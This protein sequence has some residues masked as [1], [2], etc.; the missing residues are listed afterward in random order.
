MKKAC[1]GGGVCQ[2]GEIP[3]KFWGADMDM[4]PYCVHPIAM[5][6]SPTFGR[7]T[8]YMSRA[9]HCV[10]GDKGGYQLHEEDTDCRR[11][12]NSDL[13]REGCPACGGTGQHQQKEA[14]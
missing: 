8:S 14:A 4:D 13:F 9:G 12:R 3:C 1:I 10:H 2:A 7:S 11:C 5:A 6:E